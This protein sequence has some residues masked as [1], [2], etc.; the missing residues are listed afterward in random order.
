[1]FGDLS[2]IATKGVALVF[3]ASWS[4]EIEGAW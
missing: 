3:G 1:M 4:E 2:D